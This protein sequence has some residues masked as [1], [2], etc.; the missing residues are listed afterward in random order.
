KKLF[1]YDARTN[2]FVSSTYFPFVNNW[3]INYILKDKLRQRFIFST[4]SGLVV[5]NPKTRVAAY[6]NSNPEN[7]PLVEQYRNERFINPL[8]MDA[9]HRLFVEQW[10][11]NSTHPFLLVFNF[12]TGEQKKYDLQQEYGLS[13]HTINGCLQQRS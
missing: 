6:G 9:M 1:Q 13:Y 8:Y 3:S 11:P 7:D 10:P 5:Y 12:E 4:D 2:A